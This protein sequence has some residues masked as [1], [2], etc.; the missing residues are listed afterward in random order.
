MSITRFIATLRPW[1][2]SQYVGRARAVSKDY[3]KK[4]FPVSARKLLNELHPVDLSPEPFSTRPPWLRPSDPSRLRAEARNFITGRFEFYGITREFHG[5]IEWHSQVGNYLCDV[6]LHSFRFLNAMRC[7]AEDPAQRG[8]TVRRG[9]EMIRGW[10]AQCT[11][12]HNPAWHPEV[13]SKR[14]LNWIKWLIDYPESDDAD[15]LDS[16]SRQITCLERNIETFLPGTQLVENGLALAAAGLYFFCD[17]RPR[18]WLN[19]G[20]Q[21]LK[22]TLDKQLL[23]GGGHIQRSPMYQCTL[24]E[25]LLTCC[26]L[27]LARGME[28]N[29]LL[30]KIN[31]MLQ[32]MMDL[33]HPDGRIPLLNDSV[34]GYA[35]EPAD[36][37]DYA[38][39]TFDFH[40]RTPAREYEDDGYIVF[41]DSNCFL[42]IDGGPIGPDYLPSHGHADTLSYEMS[43]D[44]KRVIVDSGVFGY[45]SDGIRAYCRGTA[46]HNTV[47]VDSCDQSEMWRAFRVGHRA[48]AFSPIVVDGERLSFFVGGHDGYQSLRCGAI[49]HRTLLHVPDEF[50]VVSDSLSGCGSHRLESH[51]HLTPGLKPEWQDDRMAV[52]DGDKT[53]LQIVPF[54]CDVPQKGY[55]WYCPRFGEKVPGADV[56]LLLVSDL[57]CHFGYFLIPGDAHAT[58]ACGFEKNES[59]YSLRRKD[60]PACIIRGNGNRYTLTVG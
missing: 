21:I 23:P 9:K 8:A 2:P 51:I 50:F 6:E 29:W 56:T 32:R 34:F 11:Y 22:S 44:G 24:L 10:V 26:N 33:L 37:L 20:T 4:A 36:I 49:H 39:R 25:E 17:G 46:A 35:P 28:P 15:I 57:P 13:I 27:F 16:L 30:Q 14:V 43:I 7:L 5:N 54:G 31:A 60:R 38:K 53:I 47:V 19:K 41:R 55:N 3:L 59:Y 48:H 58:A 1:R 18:Q 45:Q 12:P 42:I 40:P 52:I